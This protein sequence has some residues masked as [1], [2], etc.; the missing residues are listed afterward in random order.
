MMMRAAFAWV[1]VFAIVAGTSSTVQAQEAKK[2]G[3]AGAS[4]RTLTGKVSDL[5]AGDQMVTLDI[6][7]EA[8]AKPKAKGK[9]KDKDKGKDKEAGGQSWVLSLGRQTLLLRAGKNNQYA[10]IEFGEL[11]KGDSVQAV[12]SLQAESSDRSHTAWWLIVYPAGT[13]PPSR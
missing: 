13:T 3:R 10:A 5:N 12:V 2:A 6:A 11:Q 8:A 1:A 4:Y 7:S 9:D